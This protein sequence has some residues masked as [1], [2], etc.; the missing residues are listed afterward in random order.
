MSEIES[1]ILFIISNILDWF[2]I[3]KYEVNSVGLGIISIER[4]KFLSPRSL[5]TL[6]YIKTG[7]NWLLYL[8]VIFFVKSRL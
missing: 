7:V 4:E 1:R 2:P 6:K 5:G 3:F 8:K